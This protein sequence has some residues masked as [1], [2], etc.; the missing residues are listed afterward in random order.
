MIE[1]R[2]W[3]AIRIL[4]PL[5]F[6]ARYGFPIAFITPIFCISW[7]SLQP[8]KCSHT[9]HYDSLLFFLD[10]EFALRINLEVQ[11]FYNF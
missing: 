1:A 6:G 10:A 9:L 8:D 2:F 4:N 11:A 3:E 7:F 5:C